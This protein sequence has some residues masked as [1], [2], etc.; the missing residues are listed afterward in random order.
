[1]AATR[2]FVN[3]F[4]DL[5]QHIGQTGDVIGVRNHM[6][7]PFYLSTYLLLAFTKSIYRSQ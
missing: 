2:H 1:M 5:G 6:T 4:E 7:N 3:L